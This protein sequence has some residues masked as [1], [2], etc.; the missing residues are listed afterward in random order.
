[1]IRIRPGCTDDGPLPVSELIEELTRLRQRQNETTREQRQIT[2]R[3]DAVEATLKAISCRENDLAE[4]MAQV[5]G[6]RQGQLSLINSLLA[7]VLLVL[8][9]FFSM[10]WFAIQHAQLDE[11][12]RKQQEQAPQ[13]KPPPKQQAR[14]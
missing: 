11:P 14:P 1:M 13:I 6:R 12:R 8:T 9:W 3:L 4:S 5:E 2:R 10:V 7:P